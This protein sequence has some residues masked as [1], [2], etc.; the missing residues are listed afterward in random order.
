M[1]RSEAVTN[2]QFASPWGNF[3]AIVIMFA[4]LFAHGFVPFGRDGFALRHSGHKYP[5]ALSRG[6]LKV[7]QPIDRHTPAARLRGTNMKS[8]CITQRLFQQWTLA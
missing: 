6:K 1:E 4:V 5:P 7:Y 8:S 3:F 2:R